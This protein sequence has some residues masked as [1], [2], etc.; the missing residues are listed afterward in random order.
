MARSKSKRRIEVKIDGK[1]L[2][3]FAGSSDEEN[4]KEHQANHEDEDEDSSPN[5]SLKDST[6]KIEED[7]PIN[8]VGDEDEEE[9]LEPDVLVESSSAKMA[10]AMARILG[11]TKNKHGASSVVLSKTTTPLQRMQL[12]EKEQ[13]KALKEKRKTN[14]ERNLAALHIPL[15]VA[16]TNTIEIGGQSVANELEKERLHRRVATRGVVALFNAITQHQKASEVG[17]ITSI[18]HKWSPPTPHSPLLLFSVVV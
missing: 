10:N 7:D 8:D 6:M 11:T 3:R 18:A 16:T 12:K 5:S 17:R 15:S 13:V 9:I 4:P 1:E 2:D 14:R